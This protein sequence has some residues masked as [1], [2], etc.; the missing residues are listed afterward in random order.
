MRYVRGCWRPCGTVWYLR[1]ISAR[2]AIEVVSQTHGKKKP[3]RQM[4]WGRM[5]W[6]SLLVVYV[7]L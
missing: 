2:V 5:Y 4:G 7:P 6:P 3:G 1:E